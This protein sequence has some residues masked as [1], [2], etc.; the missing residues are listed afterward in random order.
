MNVCKDRNMKLNKMH[1]YRN[2]TSAYANS[3][4]FAL[5]TNI[6]DIL[7]I[8]YKCVENQRQN[9]ICRNSECS[10]NTFQKIHLLFQN[11]TESQTERTIKLRGLGITF[12]IDETAICHVFLLECPSMLP[13]DYPGITW[14]LG[15]IEEDIKRI[16]LEIFKD[17]SLS[18]FM[19]VF[20]NHLN[21]KKR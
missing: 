13:D 19:I 18:A 5:K 10:K 1:R 15:I 2:K 3:K 17:R 4:F 6:N 14:L 16:Y 12:Q 8:I 9:D 7:Y 21:F 20:E 11:Y